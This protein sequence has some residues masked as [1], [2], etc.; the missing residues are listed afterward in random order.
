M[1]EMNLNST[2]S[3]LHLEICE[4]L[5]FKIRSIS[6]EYS[7][8]IT[9]SVGRSRHSIDSDID[10]IIVSKE[11]NFNRQFLLYQK[12]IKITPL[13]IKTNFLSEK[14]LGYFVDFEGQHLNYILGTK[15]IRDPLNLIKQIQKEALEIKNYLISNVVFLEKQLELVDLAIKKNN[16]INFNRILNKLVSIK[17]LLIGVWFNSKEELRNAFFILKKNDVKF[18]NQL[19]KIVN[20]N[21]IKEQELLKLKELV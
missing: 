2:D 3:D 4:E 15:I 1:S 13:C 14:P 11:F 17:F 19:V 16:R 9:G 20:E 10:A 7:F 18:Y 6:L 12:G 5:A 21:N 8:G